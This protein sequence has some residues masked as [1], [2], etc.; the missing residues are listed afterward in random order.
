MHIL[1]TGTA[2]FIG[3]RTTELLLDQGHEVVG[4][5]NLNDYYDVRLKH[6]RLSRL[7]SHDG[8]R[9]HAIDIE[10]RPA[11]ESLFRAHRFDAVINLAARAGVRASIVDPHIYLT[12]NTQG[13]LNPHGTDGRPP[14]APL[15]DGFHLIALRGC[16]H[17]LC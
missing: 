16:R 8:F 5:D 2:G 10:D 15:P 6:Y 7:E 17:A 1:L 13:A 11:L 4:I 3:A 12:T 9:F 14:G